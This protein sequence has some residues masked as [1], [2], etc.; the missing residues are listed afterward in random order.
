MC[1]ILGSPLHVLNIHGG[2]EDADIISWMQQKIIIA[3]RMHD[4]TERVIV[5]LD[6]INTCN[7]MGLFKELVC[8]R[9]L[10]GK[11]LPNKIK[12]IAACNPYR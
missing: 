11:P 3:N 12:I 2:M 8:D 9:T 4:P 7:S 10:N 1:G 6:E 5:L